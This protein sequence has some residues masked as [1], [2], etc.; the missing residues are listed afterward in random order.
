MRQS[1]T[2]EEECGGKNIH[3]LEL[4]QIVPKLGEFTLKVRQKLF[5]FIH[6]VRVR[7]ASSRWLGIECVYSLTRRRNR[8]RLF[9][10]RVMPITRK[11]P[12]IA[13]SA[14][15]SCR[16]LPLPSHSPTQLERIRPM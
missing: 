13:M 14:A 7:V 9:S 15:A 4:A 16:T 5:K 1:I 3:G 12:G 8:A 10:H 6:G 11:G 2:V